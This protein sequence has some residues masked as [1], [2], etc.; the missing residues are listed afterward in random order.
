MSPSESARSL[1][2]VHQ[3]KAVEQVKLDVDRRTDD[4]I[5]GA[6]DII[7]IEE[8]DIMTDDQLKRNVAAK[9]LATDR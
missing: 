8:V 5:V 4:I 9:Q 6:D 3:G 2:R 1:G 7:V